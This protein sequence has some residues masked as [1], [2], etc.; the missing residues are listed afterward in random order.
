M[1]RTFIKGLFLTLISLLVIT[2]AASAQTITV[3][4]IDPGPYG[5]GS[6]ISVPFKVTGCITNPANIYTLYLSDA[7]GN[8]GSPTAIGTY[9]AFYATFIN[10]IIPNTVTAGG[11][12]KVRVGSSSP[13]VTSAPSAAFNINAVTGIKAG[14]TSAQIL[15]PAVSTE[16]FGQCSGSNRTFNFTNTSE[17]NTPATATFFN[18]LTQTNEG[19]IPLSGDFAATTANY[20]V[21]VKTT[22]AG[23][24]GT[25][26]YQL[27]NNV[28][29]N[30]FTVTGS[31]RV[32]LGAGDALE[33]NVDITGVNGIQKNYPGL[34]YKITWGDNSSNVYTLCDIIAAGGV[35]KHPYVTSSCGS[36]PNNKKNVF[37]ID[38]QPISQ[39]CSNLTQP[40]TTYAK[41]LAPA[42]NRFDA[43]VAACVGSA[44]T[45]VNN[46]VTGDDPNSTAVDCR[47]LNAKY[48]WY[49]DGVLKVSGYALSQPFVYTFTTNGNH[50]V[51]IHFENNSGLCE[52]ADL[53]KSVCVQNPPKPSFIIPALRC[54]SDGPV[55]PVNT[56]VLDENCNA[57]S[58]YKWKLVS[59]PASGVTF[60]ASAQTPQFN[61]TKTGVYK[62]QLDIATS[63]CGPESSAIQTIVV[64]SAPNANP[65][66]PDANVCGKGLTL[67]FSPN[68]ISTKTI[69][70]GT[71]EPTATTYVWTVTSAGG[72]T[73][74]YAPGSTPNSQY[75]AIT[76][77]DYD[78][79]TIKVTHTNNCGTVTDMQIL[80]FIAAPAVVAGTYA[81]VCEGTPIVLSGS[82]GVGGL[83]TGVTWVSA[84]G[85]TFTNQNSPNATYTPSAAD[86]AAGQVTLTYQ[87][88]TS[89]PAPCNV[90]IDPTTISIVKKATVTSVNT[91][92]V[93]SGSNFHY[94]ITSADPATSFNWTTALTSGT[95]TGFGAT[96][97][98][99]TINDVITN[100]TSVDAVVTYTVTPTLNGCPGI[101]FF[102]KVTVNPLPIITATATDAEICSNQP[103]NITLTSNITPT[104]YTWTSVATNGVTGATNQSTAVNITSIQDML[105]NNSAAPGTVTYTITPYNGSCPGT[106]IQAVI[107]VKP[108][109]KL[110]VPG[111]DESICAQ[112][113]YTLK[114]NDPSPGTGKWTVASGQAGITFSNDTDPHAVVSG[115]QPG[116]IYKFT[117]AISAALTCPANEN[118]V[119]IVDD[120]QTVGGTTA[121][122][123]TAVC[124]GSNDG[125]ITLTGNVGDILRW[126]SSIDNF[127]TSTAIANNTTALNFQN[128]TQTTQYRAVIK[129]GSCTFGYSSVTTITV[130][131]PV[132]KAHAGA[133]QV[134]CN[135]PTVTLDGNDPLIFSGVW[136]QTGGPTAG[137]II[138]NPTN[139]KSTVTGLTGG[140]N[141][142]FTWTINGT[143]PC[144]SESDDV[145]ITDSP[146]VPPSFTQDK[147]ESCGPLTVQFTNTSPQYP[148]VTFVWDFGDGSPVSN[149]VSPQH[150][151]PVD[152]SGKDITYTVSLT[153]T[154]NCTARPAFSRD[155]IVHP[156]VPVPRILP[157]KT[158]G[159]GPFTVTVANTSFAKYANYKYVLFDENGNE[160]QSRQT[161]DP[162]FNPQFSIT[163]PLNPK[164]YTIKLFVTNFCGQ[165]GESIPHTIIASP[166]DIKPGLK[167]ENDVRS[168]CY[169]L[170]VKLINTSSGGQDFYFHIT[171]SDGLAIP[172][173]RVVLDGSVSYT[174]PQPG[175]YYITAIAENN[176]GRIESN[177]TEHR[178][179]VFARAKPNFI[180]DKTVGKCDDVEFTFT[181]KT[182]ADPGSQ[183]SDLSYDWDFG[184][185]SPHA[186]GFT[187]IKH[188]YSPSAT[189]YTVK[190]TVSN[191]NTGCDNSE[192]KTNYIT[193]YPKPIV[194]FDAKPGLVTAIPNYHFEFLDNTNGKP[195]SWF[196]NFGD[197][198]T[199]TGRN[200]SHTYND[201]GFFD[202][203][204]TIVDDNGC[205]GTTTKKVQITG[206]P[207]FLYL[208]NAFEP[209]GSYDELRVFAAKGSGIAKWQLQIFNKWGQ[210]I[211]QTNK[212]GSNGEPIDGW[213]G[214]FRGV[215]QEQG[216]YIWQASASFI[217][218]T[219]WKGMSYNGSLPKCSGVIHLIR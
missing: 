94:T 10:G 150:T 50:D 85:G 163:P 30:S 176:C 51:T 215:A 75:P 70:N 212:L 123:T 169:P 152:A 99:N 46:S 204:L 148:G 87:A 89:L 62:F 211:W 1:G 108:L 48:S 81:P 126:E 66:S 218:G 91:Q 134:I 130:N 188:T 136:T 209:A 118:T 139:P 64:N 205:T 135:L 184:D 128:L 78:V 19:T 22:L 121:S 162:A 92:S 147:T 13:A 157:D 181:N 65:L 97:S 210:L 145:L 203:T 217:N 149:D 137:V 132:I 24:V 166:I 2:A 201:V 4:A 32:C 53:T 11:N 193:V 68:A 6:T 175:I 202:V 171:N 36:N 74:S 124:S 195:V 153:T 159:C 17:F 20:T 200:A 28:V 59:G 31:G 23:I 194:D 73:F 72:G 41:V 161:T 26:S 21:T 61:F 198:Q 182:I 18:E 80:T 12:Y 111:P 8:F 179:E 160:M 93:C 34:Q 57:N 96:G 43:P 40:V 105:I 191:P 196:W 86:I 213:D 146:D 199:A 186:N 141:Y 9:K 158:A 37:E 120:L 138:T 71:A 101:P 170:Q 39:Y 82:P 103:A 102:L 144:A 143:P 88:T 125:S 119:T 58:T 112:P 207:G 208:P 90:I 140:N 206:T 174:F 164:T 14:M 167:I 156:A 115:L 69:L 55:T 54:L 168:G 154:V 187:N 133:D 27:I 76:F 216:T 106:P 38:I 109:P 84:T 183:P 114:G 3:G 104:T 79:Y 63:S 129:S 47:N 219:Q 83:V 192:T 122:T 77:N 98:G 142:T 127:T 113:T 172:L 45:F 214:T 177:A 95:A 178:V 189:A 165:T 131:Q 180:A 110:S 100:N 5:Q 33:Y 155:I 67:N 151:F 190:L 56:S 52:A 15:N 16:V 173:Q 60:D 7:A 116:N 197:G 107:I 185:G 117:W 49:V 35:V 25:K 42:T 44:V 29:N